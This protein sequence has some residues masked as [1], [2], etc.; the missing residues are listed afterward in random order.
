MENTQNIN[1]HLNEEQEEGSL[2]RMK[3]QIET[4]ENDVTQQDYILYNTVLGKVKDLRNFTVNQIKGWIEQNWTTHDESQVRKVGK[5]FYLLCSD[6]RDR[7][8]LIEIGS[9][10][11]SRS[12]FLVHKMLP[13]LLI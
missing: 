7:A 13:L 5:L 6:A 3:I 9:A 2:R 1:L 10:K 11:F 4:E 12:P 8:N